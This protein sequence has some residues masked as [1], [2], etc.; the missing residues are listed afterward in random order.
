MPLVPRVELLMPR[1]PMW[2]MMIWLILLH[3]MQIFVMLNGLQGHV[4]EQLSSCQLSHGKYLS[5]ICRDRVSC[6]H[7]AL[8]MT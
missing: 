4:N 7:V 8:L 1:L 6:D 5:L 3:N 2:T